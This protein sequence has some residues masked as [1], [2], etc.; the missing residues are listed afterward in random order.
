MHNPESMR[1]ATGTTRG[2]LG[3]MWGTIPTKTAAARPLPCAPW[4][5]T[6]LHEATGAATGVTSAAP[7]A[8]GRG[9]SGEE[10]AE[11]RKEREK[12]RR[13]LQG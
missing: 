13:H 7:P 1:E 9:G 3:I 8:N 5:T 10:G 11:E 4:S 2:T 12:R 6:G